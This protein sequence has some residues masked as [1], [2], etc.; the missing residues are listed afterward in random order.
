MDPNQQ[1]PPQYPGGGQP[2]PGVPNQFTPQQYD[3]IMGDQQKP[4]KSL[5]PMPSGGNKKQRIIFVVIGV[6]ILLTIGT[7]LAAILSSSG[8]SST[9]SMVTVA[10]EQTEIIR[11]ARIGTT[12]AGGGTARNLAYNTQ[13]TVTSQK[14]GLV[15]YL[16]ANDRK[17]SNKELSI[18]KDSETDKKLT[19]A[20][21]NGRFDDTFVQ[22]IRDKLAK[23]QVSLKTAYN[24]SGSNG[25]ELLNKA[26]QEASVLLESANAAQ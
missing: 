19:A 18:A 22:I 23:Y 8:K 5:I 11:I 26:H 15:R 7:I 20:E 25:K 9:E 12:K 17:L 1:L 14:N 2:Q 6:L 21:T 10:A 4:K 3:F 13:L 24:A 16:N